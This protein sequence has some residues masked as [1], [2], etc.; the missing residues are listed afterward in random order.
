MELQPRNVFGNWLQTSSLLLACE[1]YSR[2]N[3]CLWPHNELSAELGTKKEWLLF[4]NEE[5][6]LENGTE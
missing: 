6:D 4:L 1:K 3:L 2:G 5:K